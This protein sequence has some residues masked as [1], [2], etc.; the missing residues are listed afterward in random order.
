MCTCNYNH[1]GMPHAPVSTTIPGMP[2]AP[3]STTIPGMPRAPV[4]YN[5]F[6]VIPTLVNRLHAGKYTGVKVRYIITIRT[7]HVQQP[8]PPLY[9]PPHLSDKTFFSNPPIFSN[10][11]AST[12]LT[13]L[14]SS[15]HGPLSDG[16]TT[17]RSQ[18]ELVAAFYWTLLN[19]YPIPR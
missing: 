6:V 18:I 4:F 3:V 8:A 11:Y 13:G 7:L 10:N 12:L 2:H 9:P 16:F 17:R 19:C 5:L 15:L 14:L 1:S